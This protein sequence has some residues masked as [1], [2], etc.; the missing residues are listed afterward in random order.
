VKVLQH[1][2]T[3][4][5]ACGSRC[6][7]RGLEAALQSTN[8]AGFERKMQKRSQVMEDLVTERD[9]GWD[10]LDKIIDGQREKWSKADVARYQKQ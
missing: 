7:S 8:I 2:L 10:K 5:Y 3:E 1:T 4:R 6:A 9:L